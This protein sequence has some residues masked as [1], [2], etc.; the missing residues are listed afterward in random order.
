MTNR[1]E[2][3]H[4]LA[5]Q[6]RQDRKDELLPL[7]W[8]KSRIAE[9]EAALRDLVRVGD[10]LKLAKDEMDRWHAAALAAESVLAASA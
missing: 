7:A 9:L 6:R 4:Q 10:S 3:V 5:E 2:R 8:Q 1:F